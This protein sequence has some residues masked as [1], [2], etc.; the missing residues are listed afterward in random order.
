MIRTDVQAKLVVLGERQDAAHASMAG[1]QRRTAVTLQVSQV[2]QMASVRALSRIV[3]LDGEC[4]EADGTEKMR[5]RRVS[6]VK[7]LDDLR[8]GRRLEQT[9]AAAVGHFARHVRL[10]QVSLQLTQVLKLFVTNQ[11]HVLLDDG[12]IL[13]ANSHL[14]FDKQKH[15]FH[16]S[17]SEQ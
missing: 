13:S 7:V 12:A 16:S 11:A 3:S 14:K 2:L 5:A 4:F 6:L 15:D 1:F 9:D 8:V 10:L 17:S